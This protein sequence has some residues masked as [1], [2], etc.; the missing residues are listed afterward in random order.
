MLHIAPGLDI[1]DEDIQLEAV[2]ASGA[3]GQH[4]NKVSSAIHLRY[5]VRRAQ[6][7]E[8]LRQRLLASRDRRLSRDGV[9]IVKAQQHRSREMNRQ[10]AYRRLA[11]WIRAA[12]RVPKP[13]KPTRPSRASRHR[14]LE[15]KRRRG[16]HKAL[17]RPPSTLE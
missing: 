3:G 10:A 14:R 7:P 17:R 8:A 12:T 5:D 9:F 13:R 1:P 4:V 15:Q 2:R 11:D 6:L 16:R